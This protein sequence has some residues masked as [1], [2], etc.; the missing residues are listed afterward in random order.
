VRQ[1]RQKCHDRESERDELTDDRERR[2][3]LALGTGEKQDEQRGRER[4]RGN[5]PEVGDDPGSHGRWGEEKN[6][7]R[8]TSNVQRPM[9]ERLLLV[10]VLTLVIDWGKGCVMIIL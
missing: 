1:R 10:I 8:S 9:E 5:Q 4:Y 2:A 7:Q 6:V 3:G